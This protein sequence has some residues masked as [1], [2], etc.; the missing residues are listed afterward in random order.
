MALDLDKLEAIARASDTT[1][2]AFQPNV[3]LELIAA[4]RATPQW[5]TDVP[6]RGVRCLVTA[7]T[8]GQPRVV[9]ASISL[10]HSDICWFSDSSISRDL[11]VDGGP[12][13]R[14]TLK[15]VIAWMPIPSPAVKP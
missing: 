10:D 11:D 1:H 4:A 9:V 15:R 3:V 14:C 7:L 12:F 6:P 8:Y 13:S 2:V 5:R